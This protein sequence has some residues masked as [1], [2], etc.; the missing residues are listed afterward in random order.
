MFTRQQ[1]GRNIHNVIFSIFRGI[2]GSAHACGDAGVLHAL[3][4]AEHHLDHPKPNP[5]WST[6][7]RASCGG[8]HGNGRERDNRDAVA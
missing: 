7:P 5:D 6:N 3:L 1:C 8:N 2:A 4:A